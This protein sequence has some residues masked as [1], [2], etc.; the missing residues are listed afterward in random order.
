MLYSYTQSGCVFFL[1]IIYHYL[2]IFSVKFFPVY[3]FI[4]L[5]VVKYRQLQQITENTLILIGVRKKTRFSLTITQ[6][7]NSSSSCS[8][9]STNMQCNNLF[10]NIWQ[11]NK[12]H[13][14][15]YEYTT[16]TLLQIALT[17]TL[18]HHSF[19]YTFH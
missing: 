2:F 13:E 15:Y 19:K 14:F 16:L 10:N 3:S 17:L 18:Y 4:W 8:S 11:R 7:T 12:K 5:R 6:N 9:S 1:S